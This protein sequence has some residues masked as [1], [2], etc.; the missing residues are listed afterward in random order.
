MQGTTLYNT[1]WHRRQRRDRKEPALSVDLAK[2]DLVRERTRCS[3]EEARAALHGANGDVVD[4]LTSLEQRTAAGDDVLAL[5]AEVVDDVQRLL[6]LG[7][8]QRL[9][10]RLGDR[11]IREVPVSVTAIGAILI[12][13]LAVLASRLTIDILRDSEDEE[14]A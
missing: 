11:T 6:S 7:P 13:L 8:I 12:G 9:R 5:T 14:K 2:V 10:I 1:S 4:A 3:Y